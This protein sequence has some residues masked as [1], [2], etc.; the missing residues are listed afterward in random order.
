MKVLLLLV[1]TNPLPVYV[2]WRLLT[3]DANSRFDKTLLVCS[4]AGGA[5]GGTEYIARSL[6]KQMN[7]G[8]DIELLT[9]EDPGDYAG[10]KEGIQQFLARLDGLV[11]VHLN[12]TGGTKVMAV[13]ASE[14]VRAAFDPEKPSVATSNSYLDPRMHRLRYQR[15]S[16]TSDSSAVDTRIHGKKKASPRLPIHARHGDSWTLQLEIQQAI[17]PCCLVGWT[18]SAIVRERVTS[19]LPP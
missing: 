3:E 10:V 14:A 1:G 19:P 8:S 11:E 5:R 16:R 2:S 18:N 12:Y 15:A 17:L 13:A 7:D 4:V 9:L 6:K